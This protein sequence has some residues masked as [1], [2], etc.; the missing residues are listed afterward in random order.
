MRLV[1]IDKFA[2]K[3]DEIRRKNGY[4]NFDDSPPPMNVVK[5]MTQA[6][7]ELPTIDA[8]QVVRCKDCK[9]SA[10]ND[11]KLVYG[12]RYCKLAFNGTLNEFDTVWDTDFCSDG[13]R[14]DNER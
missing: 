14:K 6:I 7:E 13:E 8:V 5:F 1:D 3:Y 9:H 12:A 2:E 11:G 10:E 4:I